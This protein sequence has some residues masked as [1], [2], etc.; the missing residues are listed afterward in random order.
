LGVLNTG[1]SLLGANLSTTMDRG[2]EELIRRTIQM[3][4]TRGS[5]YTVYVIGQSIQT[6]GTITNVTSSS[7]LRQV[8]QL[9]PM[10]LNTNDA[11]DPADPASRF[12]KPTGYEV[13]ILSTSYD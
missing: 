7:R 2:R 12:D 1:T 5:V 8:F 13:R 4:A 3:L 10:G 6:A 11:F 9:V